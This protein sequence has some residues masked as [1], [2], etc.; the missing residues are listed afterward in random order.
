[1]RI[2][3]RAVT[4]VT[5]DVFEQGA[6]VGRCEPVSGTWKTY[7]RQLLPRIRL[8][9]PFSSLS[10]RGAIRFQPGMTER[11]PGGKAKRDYQEEYSRSKDR[12]IARAATVDRIGF[13]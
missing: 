7:V 6:A 11:V 1:M 4:V 3:G 8:H 2:R 9:H 10:G 5:V 13:Q 12:V